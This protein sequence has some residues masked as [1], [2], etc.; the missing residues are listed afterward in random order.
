MAEVGA[1]VGWKVGFIVGL[2][3]GFV[4]DLAVGAFVLTVDAPLFPSVSRKT[5]KFGS[6][7]MLF[8]I[9]CFGIFLSNVPALVLSSLLLS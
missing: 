9:R 5:D 2:Q 3:E 8:S 7:T 4:V 1:A 6:L